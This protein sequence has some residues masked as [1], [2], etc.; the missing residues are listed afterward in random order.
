MSATLVRHRFRVV[1]YEEMVE[2]GILTEDDRVELLRGEVVEKT[3]IGPAHA[4]SVSRLNRL[5]QR[6]LGELAIVSIHSPVQLTDS[7][8]E[9]DVALLKPRDDFYASATPRADDVLL[10]VEVADSS[11][12]TDQTLKREIYAETGIPEYWIVNL[13][14]SCV[15][16]YREPIAS[17]QYG[18]M[19]RLVRGEALAPLRFPE[20]EVAVS[21]FL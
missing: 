5:F 9:P 2:R 16:V 11:L 4:A 18:V 13:V 6:R 8:P 15:E 10:I 17:G 3:T 7:Q 20:C 19:K 14:D 12:E 1:D 21:D